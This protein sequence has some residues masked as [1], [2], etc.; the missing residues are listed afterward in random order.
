MLFFLAYILNILKN[1]QDL[2]MTFAKLLNQSTCRQ[3]PAK[4]LQMS[5]ISQMLNLHVFGKVFHLSIRLW[6]LFKA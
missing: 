5:D 4:L 3:I 6:R 2:L 1:I